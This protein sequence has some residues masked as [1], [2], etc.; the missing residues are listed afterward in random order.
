M[1]FKSLPCFT[2][3]AVLAFAGPQHAA[4]QESV[5]AVPSPVTEHHEILKRDVGLWDAEVTIWPQGPQAEPVSSTGVETNRLMGDGLWL[6]SN[7][8]GEAGGQKFEGHGQFGYDPIRRKYVGTWVDSMSPFL[9]TMEG[10]YDPSSQTLT[11]ISEGRDPQTGKTV[12][13]KS[14]A[15]YV[16]EDHRTFSMSMANPAKPDEFVKVMQ[17]DYTRRGQ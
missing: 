13:S 7:F 2:F 11:M 5:S 17:I 6:I 4:A 3:I 12:K 1:P 8:K 14:E 15:R 10:T 9:N 16:D